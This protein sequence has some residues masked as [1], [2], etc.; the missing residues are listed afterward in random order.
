MTP[1]GS[2]P[3]M[4]PDRTGYSPFTMC[5]SVPQIVVAVMRMTASPALGRGFGTSS[6]RSSFRGTQRLSFCS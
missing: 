2:W 1:T 4:R 5:T 3:R 6:I